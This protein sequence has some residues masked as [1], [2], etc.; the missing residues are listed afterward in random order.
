VGLKPAPHGSV[1]DQRRRCG[2][3]MHP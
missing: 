1:A 2:V 3:L